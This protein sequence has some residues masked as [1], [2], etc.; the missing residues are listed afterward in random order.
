MNKSVFVVPARA[1]NQLNQRTGFVLPSVGT[2]SSRGRRVNCHGDWPPRIMKRHYAMPVPPTPAL[3]R[4][5]GRG[6]KVVFHVNGQS[7]LAAP[8]HET[9]PRHIRSP[10]PSPPPQAG[11][12]AWQRGEGGTLRGGHEWEEISR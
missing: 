9:Y 11:E 5:R 8:H 1:E 10:H 3:P 7:E 2:L 6:A 12:G 4:S